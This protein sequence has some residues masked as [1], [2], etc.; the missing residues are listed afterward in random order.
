MSPKQIGLETG[1]PVS[2]IYEI[3]KRMERAIML[4]LQTQ[5]VE[6][7]QHLSAAART[8]LPRPSARSIETGKNES[9]ESKLL[10][11]ANE[12]L[13]AGLVSR[14]A[15]LEKKRDAGSLTE[16]EFSELISYLIESSSCMPR[17]SKHWLIWLS[18]EAQ[19]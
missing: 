1:R 11:R 19:P 2:S 12:A 10:E 16:A 14:L 3:L 9:E 6:I 4:L 15:A 8:A 7:E 17:G 5:P 18:C 13:P